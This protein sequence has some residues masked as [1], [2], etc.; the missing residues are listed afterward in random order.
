MSKED[1]REFVNSFHYLSIYF[2]HEAKVVLWV[3]PVIIRHHIPL[4]LHRLPNLE[5]HR[6]WKRLNNVLGPVCMDF[7]KLLLEA[8]GFCSASI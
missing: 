8:E 3:L 5:S 7:G 1:D 6:D 4:L 2:S